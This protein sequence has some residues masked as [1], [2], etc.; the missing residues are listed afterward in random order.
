MMCARPADTRAMPA[1]LEAEV[2]VLGAILLDNGAINPAA[3]TLTADD[4]Y[5]EAHRLIF[6][7]MVALTENTQAIDPVT[8]A[9]E[10]TRGD[11]LDRA[12]GMGYL[13][14]LMDGLPRALNT[15]QYARIVKDKAALRKLIASANSLIKSAMNGAHDL[16]KHAE[17]L[18]IHLA[19]ISQ[20]GHK[21]SCPTLV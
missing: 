20:R 6:A 18:S 21:K 1:N 11:N 19:W 10:L 17:K 14:A 5:G 15:A 7:V 4:F 2:A 13:S 9:E 8:I 12:G 3:E 16:D